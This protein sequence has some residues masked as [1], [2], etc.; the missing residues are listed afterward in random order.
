M[1]NPSSHPPQPISSA[2]SAASRCA[3]LL[4]HFRL[5][6]SKVVIHTTRSA[7]LVQF[8][9]VWLRLSKGSLNAPDAIRPSMATALASI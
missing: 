5:E 4:R 2:V 1:V 9:S 7:H 8:F 3:F 6:P